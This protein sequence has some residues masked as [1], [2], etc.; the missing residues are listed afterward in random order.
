MIFH[1]SQHRKCRLA[2]FLLQ[3]C[4]ILRGEKTDMSVTP[5][6]HKSNQARTRSLPV[7][8][9][10]LG[11]LKIIKQVGKAPFKVNLPRIDT[12]YAASHYQ[13]SV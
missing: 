4:E 9:F 13:A 7:C 1:Q 6:S 8:P 5:L 2:A 12:I 10:I 3:L 11:I